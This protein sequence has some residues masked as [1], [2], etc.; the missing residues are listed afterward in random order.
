MK[1]RLSSNPH[2]IV[3]AARSTQPW[4]PNMKSVRLSLLICLSLFFHPSLL[5]QY[6]RVR[7]E[8]KSLHERQED[9]LGESRVKYTNTAIY[10]Y[11][12]EILCKGARNVSLSQFLDS[13]YLLRVSGRAMKTLTTRTLARHQ[14]LVLHVAHISCRWEP[15]KSFQ[16][17]GEEIIERVWDRV[18]NQG[19]RV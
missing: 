18:A 14:G 16:S 5:M 3:L 9:G 19:R 6:R 17:C 4:R 2:M 8:G 13:H 15:F 10:M 1:R 11:H 12:L 7:C